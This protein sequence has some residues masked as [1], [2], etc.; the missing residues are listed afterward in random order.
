M[1]RQHGRPVVVAE[2][3]RHIRLPLVPPTLTTGL[4]KRFNH[5]IPYHDFVSGVENGNSY[6]H[7]CSRDP[8]NSTLLT[9]IEINYP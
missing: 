8:T 6:C 4:Y 7:S 1:D 2:R 3:I 9:Y 5:C